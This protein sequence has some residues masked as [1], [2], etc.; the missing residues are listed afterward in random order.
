MNGRSQHVT[1]PAEFRFRS[2][3]VSIQRDPQNGN[4]IL[5]ELPPISEV[6]AAL[7]QALLPENFLRERDTLPAQERLDLLPQIEGE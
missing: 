3:V 2:N 1:I 7:D 6:F 5:A 4:L